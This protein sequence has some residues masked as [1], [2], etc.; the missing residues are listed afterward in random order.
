ML[1]CILFSLGHKLAGNVIVHRR[2]GMA[3]W[4]GRVDPCHAQAIVET[5]IEQG[6]VIRELYRGSMDGSFNAQK[7]LAW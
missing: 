6:E 5:T 3:V 1:F 7:K 4:Y 2:E